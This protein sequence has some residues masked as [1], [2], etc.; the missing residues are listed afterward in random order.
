MELLRRERASGCNNESAIRS[1]EVG[2]FDR[3]VIQVGNAHIGPVD[4][5]CRDVDDD[6]VGMDAI[7]RNDLAI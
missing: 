1:V 6:A 2:A 7:R 4:V 3:T 5:T